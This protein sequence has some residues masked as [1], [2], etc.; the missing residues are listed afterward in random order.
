MKISTSNLQKSFHDADRELTVIESLSFEF[1]AS[2]TIAIVGRSGI[3][4]STLMY[5]LGGLEKS[6]SGNVVYDSVDLSSMS[7]NELSS[8]RGKNIGF[9]FQSHHLLGEF[10][11]IENVAMPLII[12]GTPSTEAIEQAQVV[13][14]RVGLKERMTHRPG[15]LSGG[16]QQ[17]V[18]IARAIVTKPQVILADEPTGNLDFVTARQIQ[19]LLLQIQ[20]EMGSTMIVVTHNLELAQS[21]D[22]VFEMLPGGKLV[23]VSSSPQWEV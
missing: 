9:I 11:A 19:E 21:M 5:L 13:L 12:A 8:F 20:K 18:S 4:K 7:D 6:T 15:Q 3:G 2:G 1:P 17:R 14:E 16:E 10:D 23:P 22:F